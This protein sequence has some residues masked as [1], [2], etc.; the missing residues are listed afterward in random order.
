MTGSIMMEPAILHL[1]PVLT[2]LVLAEVEEDAVEVIA[3][4]KKDA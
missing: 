1:K 3:R 4:N 2:S